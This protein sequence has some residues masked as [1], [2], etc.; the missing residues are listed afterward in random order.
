MADII[1][2]HSRRA[3]FSA[4]RPPVFQSQAA[5]REALNRFSKIFAS[6]PKYKASVSSNCA[7]CS[8]STS[9]TPIQRSSEN[10][11]TT[12]S[13]RDKDEQAIWSGCALTS[14]TTTVSPFAQA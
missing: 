12:I 3:N 2:P 8:L 6:S 7:K 14:L 1:K 13:E 11:G 4:R 9:N 5:W 10:S